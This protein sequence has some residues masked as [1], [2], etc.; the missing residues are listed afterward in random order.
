MVSVVLPKKYPSKAFLK[1]ACD[2]AQMRSIAGRFLSNF[3][4]LSIETINRD[5]Q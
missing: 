4:G 1:V 3:A 2:R 5:L